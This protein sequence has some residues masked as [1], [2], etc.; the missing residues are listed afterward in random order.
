[1]PLSAFYMARLLLSVFVLAL[2]FVGLIGIVIGGRW[3]LRRLLGASPE[4]QAREA[5]RR[6]RARLLAPQWP[7]LEERY[8]RTI[9]KII[10]D[11]YSDQELIT[12]REV[13]LRRSD[14]KE[15]RIAE[16]MPADLKTQTTVPAQVFSRELFPIAI[17]PSGDLYCVPLNK[18]TYPV[19]MAC[20][21]GSGHELVAPS[22]VDFIAGLDRTVKPPR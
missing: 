16:F 12:L 20:R 19:E 7:E 6:T 9:P 15:W 18:G 4:E 14:G 21:D 22:V 5:A 2:L 17:S 8:R 3:L 10:K 13:V 1:M 11:F